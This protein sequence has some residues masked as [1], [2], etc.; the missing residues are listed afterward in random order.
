MA[1]RDKAIHELVVKL[2]TIVL[3]GAWLLLTV[4]EVVNVGDVAVN[5][6]I[7]VKSVGE[8]GICTVVV[9][10]HLECIASSSTRCSCGIQ[11]VGL[12]PSMEGGCCLS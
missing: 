8:L 1:S 4:T 11:T 10:G 2:D 9:G 5:K 3:V 6:V 7:C 12:I